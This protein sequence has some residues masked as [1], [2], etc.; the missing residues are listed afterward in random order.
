MKY[1]KLPKKY[2]VNK[3]NPVVWRIA[4]EVYHGWLFNRFRYPLFL[5]RPICWIKGHKNKIIYPYGCKIKQC[6]RCSLVHY[7]K[8]TAENV[9]SIYKG[10]VG[11][12]YGVRFISTNDSNSK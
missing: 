4:G 6:K 8:P 11:E 5:L 3:N 10:E 12:L 1:V 2:I 7:K 9:K